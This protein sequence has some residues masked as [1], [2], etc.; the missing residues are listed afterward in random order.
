MMQS[1]LFS[2][3]IIHQ[4][5]FEIHGKNLN[6]LTP[7]A[8]FFRMNWPESERLNY[9]P[10]RDPDNVISRQE[11]KDLANYQTADATDGA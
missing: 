8:P 4:I 9:L 2:D 10:K 7:E 3:G 11:M 6:P 5:T 1:V